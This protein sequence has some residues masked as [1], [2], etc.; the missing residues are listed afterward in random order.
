MTQRVGVMIVQVQI[1]VVFLSAVAVVCFQDLHELCIWNK[2]DRSTALSP[3]GIVGNRAID[4]HPN[5]IVF[6]QKI[7]KPGLERMCFGSVGNLRMLVKQG[8]QLFTIEVEAHGVGGVAVIIVPEP[9]D[10]AVPVVQREAAIIVGMGAN[11]IPAG[12]RAVIPKGLV[13]FQ[14][15]IDDTGIPGCIITG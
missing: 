8:V 6:I 14:P 13:L 3:Y 12:K 11:T 4:H 9:I 15:D 7:I 1:T 2:S 5:R 10:M